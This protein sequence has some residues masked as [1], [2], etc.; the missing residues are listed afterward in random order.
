[1]TTPR[2]EAIKKSRSDDISIREPHINDER[3]NKVDHY[4]VLGRLIRHGTHSFLADEQAILSLQDAQNLNELG[5]II[6]ASIAEHIAQSAR[7]PGLADALVQLGISQHQRSQIDTDRHG[8]IEGNLNSGLETFVELFKKLVTILDEA[9]GKELATHP[10]NWRI[11]DRIAKLHSERSSVYQTTYLHTRENRSLFLNQL[12]P[13]PGGGLQ[14]SAHFPNTAE[15][16]V[17]V[18]RENY[19]FLLCTE[20]IVISDEQDTI[21]LIDVPVDNPEIGCPI[22]FDNATLKALWGVFSSTASLINHWGDARSTFES[23]ALERA[24]RRDDELTDR[25]LEALASS[26]DTEAL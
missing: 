2:A 19:K 6:Q 24:L 4:G 5:H 12:E 23:W 21:R 22:T 3:D 10:E 17:W 15:I 1:M 14:F 16:S 7:T 26:D 13:A 9:Y 18:T 20:D 8:E 11:A 25:E